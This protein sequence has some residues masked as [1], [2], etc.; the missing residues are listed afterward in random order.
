[1]NTDSFVVRALNK[2]TDLLVLN[3]LFIICSLPVFTIGA[4]VT[5]MYA[6]SLRSVRY[7]DGY[8]VKTFFDAFKKNFAQSTIAWLIVMAV[9]A[10]LFFDLRFFGALSP[11]VSKICSG[12]VYVIAFFVWTVVTWLFP[13]ISKMDDTLM[14]QV[15]NSAKMAFGFFI[16]YTILCLLIQGGAVYAAIHNVPFMMMMLLL[17]FSGISYICSFFVY[18]VFSRFIDEEPASDD[19]LLYVKR[20]DDGPK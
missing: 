2:L 16:P 1:M 11:E 7:G 4:A 13:V 15:K 12:A 8:V 18:K 3:I 5:A 19:D 17:G 6:V 14:V 10:V 9:G 20:D